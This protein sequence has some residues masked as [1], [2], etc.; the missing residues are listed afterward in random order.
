MEQTYATTAQEVETRESMS[1][2]NKVKIFIKNNWF[3]LLLV[4]LAVWW[5]YF[6]E[7]SRLSIFSHDLS[8]DGSAVKVN[9]QNYRLAGHRGLTTTPTELKQF[10][11]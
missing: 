6:R 3:V 2:L 8:S 1:L 11:R 7:E 4:C 10:L 5:F 9:I